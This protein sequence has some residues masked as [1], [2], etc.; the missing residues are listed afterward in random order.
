[1]AQWEMGVGQ[2]YTSPFHVWECRGSLNKWSILS[3][4]MTKPVAESKFKASQN[5]IISCCHTPGCAIPATCTKMPFFPS[6]AAEFFSSNT[7][8]GI[9]LPPGSLP[10]LP[11]VGLSLLSFVPSMSPLHYTSYTSYHSAQ[12]LPPPLLAPSC[13][14]AGGT[15]CL[16]GKSDLQ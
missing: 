13:C 14:L 6:V 9:P 16:R 3:E 11:Q 15:H 2:E 1:M 8:L 7:Q 12:S 5:R 4:L 10:S